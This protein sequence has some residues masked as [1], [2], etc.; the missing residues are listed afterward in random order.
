MTLAGGIAAESD[1]I[2]GQSVSELSCSFHKVDWI[3]VQ[4][5]WCPNTVTC[6]EIIVRMLLKFVW[7]WLLPKAVFILWLLTR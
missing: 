4:H 5:N 1:Q 6:L 2:V 7:L 3:E